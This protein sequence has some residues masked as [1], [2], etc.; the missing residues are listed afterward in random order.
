MLELRVRTATKSDEQEACTICQDQY[1]VGRS[2]VMQLP[3][4]HVFHPT[5]VNHWL[6][7][8]TTCPV[9]RAD[10]NVALQQGDS[11]VGGVCI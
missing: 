7:S 8:H 3:C 9:C 1:A 4:G 6:G 5:C 10:C 11:K 2:T